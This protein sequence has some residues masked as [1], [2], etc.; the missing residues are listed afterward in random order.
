[1]EKASYSQV[2]AEHSKRTEG[3][4]PEDVATFH[5]TSGCKNGRD[6]DRVAFFGGIVSGTGNQTEIGKLPG[7][8][9]WSVVSGYCVRILEEELKAG[10]RYT[11][12][13]G[14]KGKQGFL[15]KPRGRDELV[16]VGEKDIRWAHER[17]I[18][19]KLPEAF[20]G[21]SHP[22]YRTAMDLVNR[23]NV[24]EIA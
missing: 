5:K 15:C 14:N 19:A 7:R 12:A 16:M 2:G 3:F 22:E 18:I 1:M 11:T 8:Q 10:W 4:V 6:G 17:V 24:N 9:T 13:S 23:T 20:M 21:E